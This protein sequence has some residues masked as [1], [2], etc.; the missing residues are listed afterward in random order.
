MYFG[1]KTSMKNWLF[2]R[3]LTGLVK[4]LSI[5]RTFYEI[6]SIC[7]EKTCCVVISSVINYLLNLNIATYYLNYY[8]NLRLELS[9]EILLRR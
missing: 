8:D 2:L 9:Y 5:I 6:W 7:R 4:M 1:Y 3:N